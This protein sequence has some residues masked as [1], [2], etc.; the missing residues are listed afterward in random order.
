MSVRTALTA[1]ALTGGLL[2]GGAA[3]AFG[4]SAATA[5][6]TSVAAF[7]PAD[8]DRDAATVS[9]GGE[10]SASAAPDMATL[11]VAVESTQ[12]TA[13]RALAAQSAAA[14]AV[15]GAVRKQGVADRDVQTE[16]LSLNAV[17]QHSDRAGSKL[18]GYQAGQSFSIRIRDLARTGAVV[19]A[20][21]GAAG[22]AVRINGVTFDVADPA[23]LRARAREAAHADA[24]AKAVQYAQLSGRRLGRLVSI[25]ETGSGT[26]RPV[27]VPG[28]AFQEG[29]MPVAPGEIRNEVA[30][31]AVYELS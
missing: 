3:P 15:L 12:P 30:V 18:T 24:R 6:P 17:Y 28:A 19:E 26:H 10:G 5:A 25:T 8:A 4:A 29:K 2:A 22:D 31:T 9:V 20:V 11:A 1:A 13:K 21:T 14:E 27:D 23:A 7:A 16:S